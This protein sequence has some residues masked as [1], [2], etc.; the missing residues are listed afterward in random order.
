MRSGCTSP[1][2]AMPYLGSGSSMV[3]PPTI[4][5]P[6]AVAMS[7]PPASNSPSSEV[8]SARWSTRRDSMRTVDGRPSRTH[9]KHCSGERRA[10]RAGI[11]DHRSDEI[12][13]RDQRSVR[14]DLPHRGI[15]AGGEA[16]PTAGRGVSMQYRATTC[17][18]SPGAS[19]QPQP[20]P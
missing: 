9:R 16:R 18:S 20:A 2:T 19:L 7:W 10:P 1:V 14:V 17:A 5:K 11:V 8:G 15:V 3:C 4:T 13:S 12:S 6:P